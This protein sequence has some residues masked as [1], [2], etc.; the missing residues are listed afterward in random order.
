MTT[1]TSSSSSQ[2][3]DSLIENSAKLSIAADNIDNNNND[4]NENNNNDN[5]TTT[6]TS[7]ATTTSS[8]ES[9]Q[10]TTATTTSSTEQQQQQT[11]QP[12]PL[13]SNLI[14]HPLQNKWSLWFDYR[15]AKTSQDQWADQLKKIISFDTVEDFWC[16]FN[17]LPAVSSIKSGS[18]FHLFK[19][20]IEP[21]WEHEANKKGGKWMVSIRDKATADN[22]WLQAVMACVGE[23]FDTSDDVCGLVYQSRKPGD[24][25]A[26]WT[27]HANNEDLTRRLGKSL[28]SAMEITGGLFGY[29]LHEDSLRTS[30]SQG[31]KNLYDV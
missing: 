9:S 22:M 13:D 10:Q 14:K 11:Q 20:G 1:S 17:N 23:T 26:I 21:K 2:Q 30:R 19:D 7:T 18:S 5:N 8:D 28:K 25:I 24:R 16:V 6:T 15:N 31:T 12:T 29:T 3:V 27:R 4:N